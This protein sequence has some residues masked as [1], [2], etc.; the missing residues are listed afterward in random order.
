MSI[1]N[2]IE[3]IRERDPAAPTFCEVVFAYPGFHVMTIFHPVAQF[4]WNMRVSGP[5]SAAS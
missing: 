1:K 4:F 2:F 5:I 3:S